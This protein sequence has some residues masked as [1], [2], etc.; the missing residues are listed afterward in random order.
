MSILIQ[1]CNRHFDYAIVGGGCFG[2]SIALAFKRE[3]P[4]ARIIWFEGTATHIAFKDITKIIRTLYP[5]K[6]YVA[7]VEQTMRMWEEAVFYRHFFHRTPWVQV[8]GVNSDRNIMKGLKNRLISTQKLVHMIGSQKSPKFGTGEELWLNENIG[9]VDSALAVEAVAEKAS[10]FGVTRETKDVTR[11]IVK[12]RVYLGVETDQCKI[13]AGTTIVTA[14]PWT[15]GL[16]QSSK[17]EV[18]IDFFT[19]INVGVVTMLLNEAE[20]C[21]LKS[22]PIL[23]TENGMF[24]FIYKILLYLTDM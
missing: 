3:W 20:F 4:D 6:D 13:I 22:M 1:E 24:Y 11:L 16:F 9:Y 15:P 21:E 12:E 19:V 7:F 2:A 18:P 23:V 10:K 14:G 8:I 5:N 17:V